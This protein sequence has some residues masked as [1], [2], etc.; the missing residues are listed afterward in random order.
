MTLS[1]NSIKHW[2]VLLEVVRCSDV[3]PASSN[4]RVSIFPTT[5]LQ[6]VAQRWKKSRR[7]F[8]ARPQTGSSTSLA[9]RGKGSEGAPCEN[10]VLG[11]EKA[12]RTLM[13]AWTRISNDLSMVKEVFLAWGE[14]RE[15]V[16]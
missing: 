3:K 4:L 9:I 7:D 2:K 1:P 12:P 10:E 6:E 13:G 11:G 16:E 14:F 15:N 8:A 5:L